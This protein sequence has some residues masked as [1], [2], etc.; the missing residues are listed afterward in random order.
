MRRYGL[1][2]DAHPAATYMLFCT[3]LAIS[4]WRFSSIRK[5]VILGFSIALFL[6]TQFFTIVRT[7]FLA[8]LIVFL[9]YE[10]LEGGI[11]RMLI[12][13][14]GF[15]SFLTISFPFLPANIRNAIVSIPLYFFSNVGFNAIT[16]SKYWAFLDTFATRLLHMK[17]GLKLVAQNPIL[18]V[19]LGKHVFVVYIPGGPMFHIYYMTI[20]AETG[21]IGFSLFL[22]IILLTLF[23]VFRSLA[24]FKRT[25]N[26]KMY[27]LTEGLLLSFI[28]I[29]LVFCS[30]PGPQEG[31]RIFW[32]L[33][34]LIAA[35]YGRMVRCGWKHK[36]DTVKNY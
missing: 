26:S 9:I 8:M 13:L 34:G 16:T 6:S 10:I 11:K 7:V 29:L 32:V 15:A 30:N 33:I 2:H 35:V 25:N 22:S 17:I 3:I 18:G 36:I 5:R 1:F 23:M 20:L 28:T 27:F 19:G 21:I 4:L 31:E 12:C 24:Y 14:F